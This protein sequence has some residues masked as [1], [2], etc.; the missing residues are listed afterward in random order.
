M[1]LNSSMDKVLERRREVEEQLSA[2][3]HLTNKDLVKKIIFKLNKFDIDN[4]T[5]STLINTGLSNL[6]GITMDSCGD[7]YVT[8][9]SSNSLHR[10][11]SDFTETEIIMDGLSNPADICYN[12]NDNII[13][14]PNSGN[15]TVDFVELD[16]NN[17]IVPERTHNRNLLKTIDILGRQTT[18]KG[19]HI[20]IYD[21]G[22]IEKKYLLK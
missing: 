17:S 3:A 4:G 13:G 19:F 11:N 6:D 15:N 2:S 5:Y 22:S 7:F 9:W 1:S 16:C 12:S 18:D 8:A 10:Y 14:I 21:N 20:E